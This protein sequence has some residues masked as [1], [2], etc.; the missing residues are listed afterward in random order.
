M[1]LSWV[2]KSTLLFS[3]FTSFIWLD[4]SNGGRLESSSTSTEQH[5]LKG[6]HDPCSRKVAI[7]AALF[8]VEGATEADLGLADAYANSCFTSS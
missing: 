8:F 1:A 4:I 6:V 5:N 3:A 7:D 2:I